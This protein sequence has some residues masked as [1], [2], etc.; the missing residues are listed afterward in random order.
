MM[1]TSGAGM[2]PTGYI[3]ASA[4]AAGSRADRAIVIDDDDD[5][6]AMQIDA[7]SSRAGG[8]LTT[9]LFIHYFSL[10]VLFA[11]IN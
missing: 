8:E 10:L 2:G 3:S 6:N 5:V 7:S 1:F 11:I 4:A 9:Y